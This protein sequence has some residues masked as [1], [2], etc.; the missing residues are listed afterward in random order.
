MTPREPMPEVA[1]ARNALRM[2][3]SLSM[4]SRWQVE[5][6]LIDQG[7]GTDLCRL[8]TGRLDLKMRHIVAICRVLACTRWSS[9]ASC[10]RSPRSGARSYSRSKLCSG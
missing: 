10:S 1:R 2:L 9:S 3:I 7:C 5:N 8:L 6:R 4:M